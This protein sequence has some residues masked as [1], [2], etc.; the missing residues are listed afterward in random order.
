MDNGGDVFG[1]IIVGLALFAIGASMAVA[2]DRR[3]SRF[4]WS[5]LA[6]WGFW[7][8]ATSSMNLGTG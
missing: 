5:L 3:R 8:L 1:T 6:L 2:A 4:L 7:V